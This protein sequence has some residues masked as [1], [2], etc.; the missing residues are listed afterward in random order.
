MDSPVLPAS[1]ALRRGRTLIA[2]RGQQHPKPAVR[3]GLGGRI[4]P[5]RVVEG[6]AD[7]LDGAA[8]VALTAAGLDRRVQDLRHA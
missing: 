4:G 1:Q 8:G 5:P 2:G 6:A 3:I 7:H